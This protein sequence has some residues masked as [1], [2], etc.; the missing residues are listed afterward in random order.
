MTRLYTWQECAELDAATTR[1]LYRQYVNGSQV[2][3]LGLFEFGRD[4]AV[5]AEGMYISTASGRRVLDFTGGFGVLSHGHN[6]PRI[7]AA[8][9]EFQRQARMEVHKNFVSQYVAGLSHN[10]GRLLPEDLDVSYFCNSGAEA[11]EGAIKLAYKYHEGRRKHVLHSNISFHGNLLGAASITAS[12]ERKFPFPGIPN[13]AS[14]PYDSI[15]GV[16]REV[17]RLRRDDGESDVYA[18][19]LEPFSASTMTACSDDFLV[20]LRR[21]CADERIVLV[22]DEVYTGWAK[23]GPLFYFMKSGVVPDVVA[24]SKALGGGK[25]SISCYTARGPLFRA[26]YDNVSDVTLHSTTYN[27]FGEECV[28]AIE[29][30]NIVVDDDYVGRAHHIGDRLGAGLAEIRDRHPDMVREIRG[31][32]A[33]FGLVLNAEAGPVVRAAANVAP[34]AL[35]HDERFFD[36]L[37]TSSVVAELYRSHDVLTF[38]RSNREIV[39]V[40]SPALIATDGEIDRFLDALDQTLAVGKLNLVARFARDYLSRKVPGTRLA[41]PARRLVGH[42]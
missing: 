41:E 14:F 15:E 7:L 1:E 13:V 5:S 19:V 22:F 8:R 28:T 20:D 25:S 26:A 9:T 38:F 42:G 23:A 33:L 10:I 39:L 2:D 24:M 12:P 16:R 29:A 6:H 17:E 18:I 37:V 4:V 30:V 32:G 3:L 21:L 27:G 36:K 11:V 31:E 35:F 40:V 34:G